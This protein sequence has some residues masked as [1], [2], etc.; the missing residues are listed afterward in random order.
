MDIEKILENL[1]KRNYVT[2]DFETKEE[3][4]SHIASQV[5]GKSVGFGD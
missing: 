1:R 3:A 4:A 5:H 2:S